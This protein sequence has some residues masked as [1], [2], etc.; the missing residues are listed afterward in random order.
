MMSKRRR[1]AVAQQPLRLAGNNGAKGITT[2]MILITP[3]MAEKWL[4]GNTHNRKLRQDRVDEFIADLKAGRWL[5]THQGIAFDENGVLIDGQHRLYAIWYSGISAKALVTRG[6]PLDTQY[7]IDTGL[8]RA[9]HDTLTLMGSHLPGV[10]ATT[11][12]HAAILRWVTLGLEGA[13]KSTRMKAPEARQGIEKYGDAVG[14]A[15]ARLGAPKVRLLTAPI[16][17][18]VARAYYTSEPARL[19]EFCHVLRTGQITDPSDG[20]A[21]RLRE[22]LLA[23]TGGGKEVARAR[24]TKT[25]RAIRA[26]LDRDPI[27]RVFAAEQ[28]LFPLPG[29]KAPKPAARARKEVQARQKR[30][31]GRG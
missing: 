7:V 10:N 11:M 9:V 2:E 17:A 20:A 12:L 29:E 8:P 23:T 24:Y 27:S 16:Y 15:C 18:A 6:L 21:I 31:T 14:W 4:E 1:Q 28:E 3:A 13:S 26:F 30:I 25:E 19:E 22:T 5:V